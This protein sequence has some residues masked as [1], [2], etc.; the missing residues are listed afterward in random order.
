MGF[1]NACQD[2]FNSDSRKYLILHT[3]QM[4][5]EHAMPFSSENANHFHAGIILML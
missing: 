5:H 4:H 1:K 3:G 2:F